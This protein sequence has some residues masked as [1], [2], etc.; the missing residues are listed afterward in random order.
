MAWGPAITVSS[1]RLQA[2]ILPSSTTPLA[3]F[4]T[5]RKLTA[6]V[7][8][9]G[10]GVGCILDQADLRHRYL[11]HRRA[12]LKPFEG[13]YNLVKSPYSLNEDNLTM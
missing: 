2:V 9:L 4:A 8:K 3:R 10:L 6:Y 12:E 5:G 11:D 1:P 7:P 13:A